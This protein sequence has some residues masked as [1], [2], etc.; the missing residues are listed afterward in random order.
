LPTA[1]PPPRRVEKKRELSIFSVVFNTFL[2]VSALA[3]TFAL[4]VREEEYALAGP[5]VETAAPRTTPG[6]TGELKQVPP[7]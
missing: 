6:I 1:L 5:Q 7:G 4:L 2:V 3:L